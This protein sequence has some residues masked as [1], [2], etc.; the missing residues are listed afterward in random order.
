MT[1]RDVDQL[2]AEEYRAFWDYVEQEVREQERQ[3]R[4]AKRGRH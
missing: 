3:A 4:R 2:T 1:P